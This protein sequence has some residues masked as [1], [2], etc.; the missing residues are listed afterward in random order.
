M[1]SIPLINRPRYYLIHWIQSIWLIITP[2]IL[3]IFYHFQ[4]PQR[5]LCW[6]HNTLTKSILK[7]TISITIIPLPTTSPQTASILLI[8]LSPPRQ[9]FLNQLLSSRW[10][11]KTLILLKCYHLHYRPI[12]S[13]QADSTFRRTR[14][15]DNLR[16]LTTDLYANL[17]CNKRVDFAQR[18]LITCM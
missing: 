12:I 3:T 2:Q 9:Q 1:N 15:T 6:C 16:T 11:I 8:L 10:S 14:L 13:F 17:C 4:L 18:F 7:C 5:L